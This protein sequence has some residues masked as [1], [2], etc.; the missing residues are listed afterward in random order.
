MMV[1]ALGGISTARIA[2]RGCILVMLSDLESKSLHHQAFA[3]GRH[4][5]HGNKCYGQ[6][7][8]NRHMRPGAQMYGKTLLKDLEGDLSGHAKMFF[9]RL[10]T[11]SATLAASAT[12]QP[13]TPHG[14]SARQRGGSAGL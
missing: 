11:V 13:A 10:I 4:L 2:S 8:A 7:M 12:A 1:G 3:Y 9:T 5:R 14:L 6:R